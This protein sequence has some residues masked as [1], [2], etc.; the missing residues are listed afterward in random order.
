MNIHEFQ[1][2]ALLA[3]YGLPAPRGGI[4]ESPEAAAGVAKELG[5]GP[6]MVKAQ[7]LAGDR[8]KAGGVRRA[9]TPHAVEQTAST[10]LGQTLVT[11]QTG[12]TG[13]TVKRVLVEQAHEIDREL[14]L[15]LLVDRTAGRLALLGTT[16]GGEDIEARV[17][18]DPD[19]I[20]R[21]LI[22]PLAGLSADQAESM[23]ARL[24]LDGAAAEAAVQLMQDLARAFVATDASLIEINPLALTRDGALLA[25]D[26]K[27]SLDDNALFRHPEHEP[28]RDQD[29]EDP[30]ELEAQ[31][32][33]VNFVK[34]EGDIGCV[35]NGAGLA[36]ATI[37]LLQAEGGQPA[38]FMDIR[39]SATRDQ[40][41][42]AFGMVLDNPKVRAILVN[43]YGGG[44]LKCDTIGEGIAAAMRKRSRDLPLIVRAAGTNADI[45]RKALTAQAVPVTFA[46]D[47]A[48]AA[49]LAVAAVKREAA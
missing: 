9:E 6:F 37:D 10:L 4:A 38:D 14:Y 29:A 46:S 44:V 48:E 18:A 34:L 26:V 22:D 42:T 17:A 40:V 35:V 47:M 12:G 13:Q 31:R 24:G 49:R 16:K 3:D 45:C 23:A 20:L 1:A 33:E 21:E 25:L 15:A 19:A 7:I 27:M 39:P 8:G 32:Y 30:S 5:G 36:L 2:K 28:L 11:R 43:V 41:A